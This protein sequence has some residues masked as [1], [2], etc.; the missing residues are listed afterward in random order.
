MDRVR[1]TFTVNGTLMTQDFP[2]E[3]AA[4]DA[5]QVEGK[6]YRVL[7]CDGGHLELEPM[8][9][10]KWACTACTGPAS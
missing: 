7:N 9:N 3:A 6:L 4:G 5:V 8:G 1:H 10:W 2:A